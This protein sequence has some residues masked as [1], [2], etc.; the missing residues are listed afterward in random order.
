MQFDPSAFVADPE[1][2]QAL[3]ERSTLLNCDGEQVLFQQGEPVVGLYIVK[4]GEAELSLIGGDGTPILAVKTGAGALLGLPGMLGD[5]GYSMTGVARQGA[6]IGFV[7]RSDFNAL[8]VA[9]PQLSL[10]MRQVLAAEVRTA[11]AWRQVLA[12]SWSRL[13]GLHWRPAA[14][15]WLFWPCVVMSRWHP[16]LPPQ[17]FLYGRGC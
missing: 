5:N 9:N 16:S 3:E 12:A 8:M 2:F 11:K 1:L 6:E 15:A 7:G 14:C 13:R 10:Q 17:A 4:K